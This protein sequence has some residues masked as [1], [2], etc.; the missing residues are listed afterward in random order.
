MEIAVAFKNSLLLCNSFFTNVPFSYL[1]WT[2]VK[3]TILQSSCVFWIPHNHITIAVDMFHYQS[4]LGNA[5]AVHTFITEFRRNLS[6]R[7]FWL[8]YSFRHTH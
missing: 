7:S 2:N 1:S 8:N 6:V 5:W 4:H 3:A